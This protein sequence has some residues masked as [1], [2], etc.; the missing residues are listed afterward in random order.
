MG[1]KAADVRG[2]QPHHLH[3]PNVMEIWE[4]NFLEPSGP[5]RTCYGTALLYFYIVNKEVRNKETDS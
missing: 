3:V 1:V 4:P 2:W 5:H